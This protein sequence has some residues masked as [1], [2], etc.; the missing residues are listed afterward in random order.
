[1][2]HQFSPVTNSIY[3]AICF[4]DHEMCFVLYMVISFSS[5]TTNEKQ[6]NKQIGICFKAL[7][8]CFAYHMFFVCAKSLLTTTVI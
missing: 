2:N 7:C 8:S 6:K 5:L 1:M 4:Q 3:I